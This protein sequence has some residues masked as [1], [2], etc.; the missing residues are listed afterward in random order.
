MQIFIANDFDK[1]KFDGKPSAT[2]NSFM[3]VEKLELK[4]GA[5]VMAIK[6]IDADLVNGSV[7]KVIGFGYD[8]D[9]DNDDDSFA[10]KGEDGFEPDRKKLKLAMAVGTGKAEM[11]PR[12]EFK[13]HNG[14]MRTV[15]M[16]R[17]DWSVEDS[18][19]VIT[20]S[21]NQVSLVLLFL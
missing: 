1:Y 17:E 8:H 21:R 16:K 5:Q 13:L 3:A 19:R 18:S 9:D 20:A 14:D 15:T 11:A 7:G 10:V 2:I 4:V 12:V 6:N